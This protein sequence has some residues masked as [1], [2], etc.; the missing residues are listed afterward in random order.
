M[1]DFSLHHTKFVMNVRDQ[2][3]FKIFVELMKK[4]IFCLLLVGVSR[5]GKSV[6][7]YIAI[8]DSRITIRIAIYCRGVLL[9]KKDQTNKEIHLHVE[10]FPP[11]CKQNIP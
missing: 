5:Y 6:L 7:R 4:T 1:S 9:L 3:L 8:H 10:S 2:N 11:I